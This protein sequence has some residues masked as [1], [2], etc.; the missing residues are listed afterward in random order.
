MT[1]LISGRIA[2]CTFALALGAA[3]VLAQ[4]S[5]PTAADLARGIQ[6][7]YD[8]GTVEVYRSTDRAGVIDVY[9]EDPFGYAYRML[10]A[11]GTHLLMY[12]EVV[13]GASDPNS[14]Q[15]YDYGV[16]VANM[17]VPF[18][19]GRWAVDVI[20]TTV[21]GPRSETQVQA[22]D[23]IVTQRIGPCRY[24]RIEA[25]IAYDTADDYIEGIHFLPELGLGYLVW[26]E[27]YGATAMDLTPVAIAPVR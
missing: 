8:D 13:N 12:E 22:Y 15:T 4:T 23:A 17:P 7:T 6:L 26:S 5:C 14:R 24:D 27:S 19:G 1:M 21:E 11:H 9:G 20:A 10:I 3:P 25:V 2:A 18:P 16:S